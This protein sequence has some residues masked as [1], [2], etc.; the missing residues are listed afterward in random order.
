MKDETQNFPKKSSLENGDSGS[1]FL[2]PSSTTSRTPALRT[3][4]SSS[5]AS[6][7][8]GGGWE[9]MGLL[10]GGRREKTGKLFG[11]WPWVFVYCVCFVAK[12]LYFFGGGGNFF[13]KNRFEMA[14]QAFKSNDHTSAIQRSYGFFPFF[15]GKY[16]HRC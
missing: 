9:V 14:N 4:K 15:I 7:E 8:N 10:N 1:C 12:S 3:S 5:S 16:I 2:V 13:D 6:G 11:V